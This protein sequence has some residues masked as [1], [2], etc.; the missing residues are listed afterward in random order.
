MGGS[1]LSLY[2]SGCRGVRP[3]AQSLF[4]VSPKKSNP[5]KGDPAGC[6]PQQSCWQPA[7]RRFGGEPQKFACRLRHSRFL[8]R[9]ST[10]A[11]AQPEGIGGTSRL[12]ALRATSPVSGAG[13]N[14]RAVAELGS[15]PISMSHTGSSILTFI[16]MGSDPNS[17]ADR[18]GAVVGYPLPVMAS[19]SSVPEMG[20][21][22]NSAVCGARSA[23]SPA[24]GFPGA[25]GS[26]PKFAD[27][28]SGA[29]V[30]YPRP[31]ME[32]RYA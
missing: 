21:D 15:D 6:D 3:A 24:S 1:L 12:V 26:D 11:Q 31:V 2:R 13:G 32:H 14:W 18:S 20:S 8:S 4:F 17:A 9:Q 25:F 10:A 30:G 16:E 23:I 7:L 19:I 28:R 27:D 22:P 5:K 29:V